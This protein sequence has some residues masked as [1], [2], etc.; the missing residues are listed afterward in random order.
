MTLLCFSDSISED[1][2]PDEVIQSL[3]RLSP[4][5]QFPN[6]KP[7]ISPRPKP[8]LAM[9]PVVPPRCESQPNNHKE[10]GEPVGKVP[11]KLESSESLASNSEIIKIHSSI[12]SAISSESSAKSYT[13]SFDD[14]FAKL[15]PSV[16]SS[17]SPLKCESRKG[18]MPFVTLK[19][20]RSYAESVSVDDDDDVFSE[21]LKLGRAVSTSE[22]PQ[23]QS[24]CGSQN[25]VLSMIPMP[26]TGGA[27]QQFP[28][29]GSTIGE[30]DVDSPSNKNII[31]TTEA[32]EISVENTPVRN[33]IKNGDRSSESVKPLERK[34]KPVVMK[35]SKVSSSSSDGSNSAGSEVK[36]E[37]IVMRNT[38]LK[39][40]S[41]YSQSTSSKCDFS[42]VDISG[43]VMRRPKYMSEESDVQPQDEAER[44]IQSAIIRQP[45]QMVSHKDKPVVGR[46]QSEAVHVTPPPKLPLRQADTNLFRKQAAER[47]KSGESAFIKRTGVQMRLKGENSPLRRYKSGPPATLVNDSPEWVESGREP[48]ER[49]Q[50]HSPKTPPPIPTKPTMRKSVSAIPSPSGSEVNEDPLGGSTKE[51]ASS[52]STD[53][54]HKAANMNNEAEKSKKV[55]DIN[56][57]FPDIPPLPHPRLELTYR[58]AFDDIRLFIANNRRPNEIYAVPRLSERGG[59]AITKLKQYLQKVE[60]M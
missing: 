42:T 39:P 48:E 59:K 30:T 43:V 32:V 10:D 11:L 54:P 38:K 19:N 18:A 33:S 31:Q 3:S 14:T 17:E 46:T 15:S 27:E 49:T 40:N 51:S 57:N 7:P 47:K 50:S 12:D 60:G 53:L 24:P 41:S 44:G 8:S 36:V 1:E 5:R 22:V 21:D 13:Q 28:I 20:S 9:S 45:G 52:D 37:P 25:K 2:L 6:K 56:F 35:R 16:F 23:T 55:V 29:L 4:I 58:S 26:P 34:I